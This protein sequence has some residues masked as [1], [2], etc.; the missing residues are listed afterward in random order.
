M[1]LMVLSLFN[2]LKKNMKKSVLSLLILLFFSSMLTAQIN[3][4]GVANNQQTGKI[5]VVKWEALNPASVSVF[6]SMLDG[7]YFASSAFDSYNSNYYLTGISGDNSGLY[8][9]NTRT[10]QENL[11]S[12]SLYSNISEF[13][14]STGIMYNLKMMADD[15]I[16][17]FAYN[18]NTNQDS[19]L[20]VIYEP[21][22]NGIV[23]DAIGFDANNGILYYV[24]FTGDPALCL[25]AIPV[26]ESQFSFTKTNLVTNAPY[27]NIQSV[28]FDNV[29]E[30]IFARNA[31]FDTT[32]TYISSFIVEINK[33]T[34]DI[35]NLAELVEFPYFVGGSSSFD[36]NTG[37][38]MLVG[39]DTSNML[40]MIAFNSSD[41]TYVSGFVPGNISEIVCDNSEF[42]QN[43]YILT[44]VKAETAI[45]FDVY[46]NPATELLTIDYP[47]TEKLNIQLISSDGKRVLSQD[48]ASGERLVMNVAD[49]LPGLYLVKLLSG[50]KTAT[51]K[52]VLR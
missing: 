46:P 2:K 16:S 7:Y 23:V 30:R 40:K 43:N 21:G 6:P 3:L 33:T 8:S 49:L 31:T 29:N 15:S 24:G 17:V 41:N 37:T 14:M 19:L 34:G 51:Q 13:D 22:V 35:I 11:G 9:F 5:D 42:V 26:R 52:I 12:A 48:F 47:T 50:G 27:N 25:Y 45:S 39:I 18:I 1:N 4:V 20:G 10:N 28:N 32:G 36:Q 44:G 38:L